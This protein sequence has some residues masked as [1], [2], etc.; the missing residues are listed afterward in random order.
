MSDID[1]KEL[2]EKLDRVLININYVYNLLADIFVRL[3]TQ[4]DMIYKMYNHKC[5]EVLDVDTRK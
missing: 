3:D 1:C 5:I 2:S 4:G